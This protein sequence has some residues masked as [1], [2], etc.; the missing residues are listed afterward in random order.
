MQVQAGTDARTVS[1]QLGHATVAFT[2]QTY[3]HPD[4]AAAAAAADT[5]ERLIGSVGLD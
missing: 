2:M 1:D 5:M 4:E 3:L